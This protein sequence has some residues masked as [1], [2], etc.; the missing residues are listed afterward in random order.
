MGVFAALEVD[1]L[2]ALLSKNYQYEAFGVATSPTKMD[3]EVYA[4]VMH[5]LSAGVTKMDVSAQQQRIILIPA[6]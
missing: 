3:R 6:N 1:K 4:K 5:G 2:M